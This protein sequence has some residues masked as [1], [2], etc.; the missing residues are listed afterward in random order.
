MNDKKISLS[1]VV[2]V[3]NESENL[4]ELFRKL[5]KILP[6]L[7]P[8]YE[9]IFVNDG[10]NDEC[11]EILNVFFD[12]NN[13]VSVI[14]LYKNFGKTPALE[15][16]FAIARGDIIATLDSDLQNDP[17]DIGRLVNKVR[18]GYDLVSGMR[19]GRQDPGGKILTSRLFNWI[20]RQTTGLRLKDYFSGMRCY[21]KK[22][23]KALDLH[24][25]LYRFAL[26]FAHF[27]GFKVAEVPIRHNPRLH[28]DSKYSKY[29]RLKRGLSD[30]LIVLFTIKFNYRRIYLL[31]VWGLILTG[32]GLTV[33]FLHFLANLW[34]IAVGGGDVFI[35]A[36][37]IIIFSGL[38]FLIFKKIADNFVAYHQSAKDKR[39]KYIKDILF[40][41]G[42]EFREE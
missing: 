21:R 8:D 28:G 20:I 1:V 41:S 33:L 7:T 27:D 14:H 39:K 18:E 16:G 30:L 32:I 3:Y 25:D 10:S 26:V 9:I 19:Q 15:Q 11:E 4:P 34:G 29:T 31:G 6:G 40:H 36:V 12:E 35:A 17:D 22:V 37:A 2:P 5:K 42:N 23:L 24:G 38:Q 13:F